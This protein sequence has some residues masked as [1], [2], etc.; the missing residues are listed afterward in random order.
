MVSKMLIHNEKDLV[1]VVTQD[2]IDGEEVEGVYMDTH[3]KIKLKAI[4]PIPLGHKMA[5]K[6][7]KQNELV[8]EYGEPIGKATAN[9]K[10][11]EHVHTNNLKTMRW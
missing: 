5:L 1:G 8:I 10:M 3:K 4:S 6:D 11:G 9:I 7:I 2:I